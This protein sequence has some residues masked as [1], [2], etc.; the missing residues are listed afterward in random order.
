MLSGHLIWHYKLSMCSSNWLHSKKVKIINFIPIS[1]FINIVL[2]L[3]ILSSPPQQHYTTSTS[4]E[5][6]KGKLSYLWD[7]YVVNPEYWP[8]WLTHFS[9][10][11]ATYSIKQFLLSH[12][13]IG[14]DRW[15]NK[16]AVFIALHFD[17][18]SI[19]KKTGTFFYSFLN[20]VA[21]PLLGLGTD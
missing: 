2:S 10:D 11:P 20:Q 4:L 21:N 17:I 12:L 8:I 3:G 13:D 9:N 19:Q 7:F 15:S 14:K 16:I 5:L 1:N 18:T 6:C